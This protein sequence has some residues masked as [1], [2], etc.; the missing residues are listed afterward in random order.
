MSIN[1]VTNEEKR[2][3]DYANTDLYNQFRQAAEV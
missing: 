1:R 3:L 2:A